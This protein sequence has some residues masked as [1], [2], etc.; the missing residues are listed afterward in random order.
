MPKGRD[1]I[2]KARAKN[3]GA[4]NALPSKLNKNSADSPYR[5]LPFESLVSD[6][7]KN[8]YNALAKNTSSLES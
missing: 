5:L 8:L 7:P 1:G 4:S 2:L 3:F 6:I